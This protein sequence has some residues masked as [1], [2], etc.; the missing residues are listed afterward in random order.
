MRGMPNVHYIGIDLPENILVQSWYLKNTLP[1]RRVAFQTDADMSD[2]TEADALPLRNW[3]IER[4]NLPRLDLV[5][6]V[7]SFGEMNLASLEAYFGEIVRLAP[8]WVFHDNLAAPRRDSLYGI[9][10]SEYPALPGYQLIAA[11]ESRWPRYDPSS[12][13]PCREQLFQRI[14]S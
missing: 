8:E 2:I 10:S 7:H 3:A 4:L 6:N 11:C 12:L 9:P 1:D 14:R 13:Y 5:V